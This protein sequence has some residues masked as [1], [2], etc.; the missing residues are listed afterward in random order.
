MNMKVKKASTR[1]VVWV[2]QRDGIIYQLYITSYDQAS[3]TKD[4]LSK[5]SAEIRRRQL[6]L[7]ASLTHPQ[8][9]E[10]VV[11]SQHHK[12]KRTSMGQRQYQLSFP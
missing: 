3:Y 12:Y 6:S 7:Q 9:A 11:H 10:K 5:C 4:Q 8:C 1:Q 2:N